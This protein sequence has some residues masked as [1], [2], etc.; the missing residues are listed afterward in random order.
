MA[1]VKSG[2]RPLVSGARCGS[3][4]V[5]AVIFLLSVYFLRLLSFAIQKVL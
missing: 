2:R 3:E 5:K 4:A 1:G